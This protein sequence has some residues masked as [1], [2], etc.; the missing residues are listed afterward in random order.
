MPTLFATVAVM[1]A[2]GPLSLGAT[3]DP[4]GIDIGTT[5]VQLGLSA[6]FLWQ[7]LRA[8]AHAKKRDD[9]IL[10]LSSTLGPALAR[11]GDLMS[12][13]EQNV[14]QTYVSPRPPE[15]IDRLDRLEHALV[16]MGDTLRAVVETRTKDHDAEA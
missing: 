1:W 14:A 4:S 11:A 2:V 16:Q 10:E 8:D 15:G 3:G 7:W 5:I 12:R 6:V 13:F 9:Q